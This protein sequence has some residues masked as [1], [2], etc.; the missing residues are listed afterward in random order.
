MSRPRSALNS[1]GV[2]GRDEGWGQRP[3]QTG[4]RGG[5]WKA[6]PRRDTRQDEAIREV[7]RKNPSG[8]DA[9][10]KPRGRALFEEVGTETEEMEPD[11]ETWR[12]N[13][14]DDTTQIRRPR[15]HRGR[16]PAVAL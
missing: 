7:I 9:A 16:F 10:S 5:G 2:E 6:R 4:H 12:V 14:A 15:G 3:A 11:S 13:Q 8:A 1:C